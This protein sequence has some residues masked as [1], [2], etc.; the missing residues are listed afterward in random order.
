MTLERDTPAQGGGTVQLGGENSSS[1]R[2]KP[3][4]RQSQDGP[5]VHLLKRCTCSA[6]VDKCK[7]L[8][9]VVVCNSGTETLVR[10]ANAPWG[11]GRTDCVF[12]HLPL[13]KES[14]KAA[15]YAAELE[16]RLAMAAWKEHDRRERLQDARRRE[17]GQ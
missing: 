14:K 17:Q 12:L 5:P 4:K 13:H 7:C 15:A 6:T 10:L 8:P 11:W 3:A 1:L 16:Q 2:A 9:R